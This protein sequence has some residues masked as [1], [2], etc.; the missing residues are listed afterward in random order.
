MAPY[1]NCIVYSAAAECTF[2]SAAHGIFSKINNVLGH[3]GHLNK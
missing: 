1:I 2:F 3:K